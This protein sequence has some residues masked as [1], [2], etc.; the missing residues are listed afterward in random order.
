M[1]T[2][3]KLS[4]KSS[5]RRLGQA[6]LALALGLVGMQAA[7]STTTAADGT[8]TTTVN[9]AQFVAYAQVVLGAVTTILSVAAVASAVGAP[10]VAA[11]SA[12]STVLNAA[13]GAFSTATAGVLS[14]TMDNTSLATQVRSVLAAMSTVLSD[15]KALPAALAGKIGSGDLANVNTGLG[16]AETAVALIQALAGLVGVS[17]GVH[18]K[19]RMT[20]PAMFRAV[21]MSVP[22]W[23]AAE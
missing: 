5:R 15:L 3:S 7:C 2:G 18:T 12:A 19:V 4:A 10:A 16:A 20:H 1:T 21:G 11:I 14:F 9:V 8:T 6:G 13:L 23:V 22:A 17:G